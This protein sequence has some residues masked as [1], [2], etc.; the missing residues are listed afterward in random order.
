M[1]N[2]KPKTKYNIVTI[3]LAVPASIPISEVCDGLNEMLYNGLR[4]AD[5][6]FDDFQHEINPTAVKTGKSPEEGDL[7]ASPVLDGNVPTYKATPA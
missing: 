3:Q 2:L 5:A 1:H 7:F 4:A 6:V